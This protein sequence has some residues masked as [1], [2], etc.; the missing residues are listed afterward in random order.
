MAKI[1]GSHSDGS[2]CYTVGCSLQVT[3]STRVDSPL[4]SEIRELKLAS[5]IKAMANLMKSRAFYGK[6]DPTYTMGPSTF[7]KKME[8]ASSTE[9]AVELIKEALFSRKLKN[10]EALSRAWKLISANPLTP[11]PILYKAALYHVSLA[12]LQ[13]VLENPSLSAQSVNKLGMRFSNPNHSSMSDSYI[14]QKRIALSWVAAHPKT[15][16]EAL[17]QLTEDGWGADVDRAILD[18]SNVSIKSLEFM[19]I[20]RRSNQAAGQQARFMLKDRL[21]A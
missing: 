17:N 2:N 14:E 3:P 7:K 13:K 12:H 4:I 21:K 18:N 5:D 8:E 20:N 10:I 19:S 1:I 6:Y 11:D 15:S 9:A 16:S